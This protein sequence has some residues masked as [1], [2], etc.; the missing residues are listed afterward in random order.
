MIA[1]PRCPYGESLRE[2]AESLLKLSKGCAAIPFNVQDGCTDV[3]R[4]NADIV[5]RIVAPPFVDC[6]NIG[7]GV[8]ISIRA[9]RLFA[10]WQAWE[11]RRSISSAFPRSRV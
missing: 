9:C 11:Y 3:F 1:A 4:A 8:L 7:S 5:I 6:F 10:I 2:L